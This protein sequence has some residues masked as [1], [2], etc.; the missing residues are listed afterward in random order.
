ME[1]ASQHISYVV[2]NGTSRVRHLL[3][4]IETADPT[5]CS[6]KT[7]IVADS[8]MKNDFE[9]A[10][11]FLLI[12]APTAKKEQTHRISSL[13]TKRKGRKK[14]KVKTGPKTGVELC[15]YKRNEWLD[16]SQDE[17]DE[18]VEICRNSREK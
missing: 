4:S 6:S 16:L 7:T 11:N 15:F 12:N 8:V 9:A 3:N 10:A 5:I 13:K 14:E 1:R 18:V 17:R 2:P